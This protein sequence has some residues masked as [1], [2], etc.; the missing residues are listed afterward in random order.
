MVEY[1]NKIG[2]VP[3]GELYEEVELDNGKNI[4]VN[5][6]VVEW[7]EP[8]LDERST[9]DGHRVN[10]MVTT[11]VVDKIYKRPNGPE[12]SIKNADL[13]R[14]PSNSQYLQIPAERSDMFLSR[15]AEGCI[16]EYW[17]NGDHDMEIR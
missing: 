2:E 16:I 13:G 6:T 15:N 10:S 12:I 17:Y 9:R 3:V 14:L 7:D 11:G 1:K 5:E 8:D 4:K